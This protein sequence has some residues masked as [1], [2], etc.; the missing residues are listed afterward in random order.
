VTTFFQL[1]LD[2][3]INREALRS[4]I[5]SGAAGTDVPSLH[6]FLE[7]LSGNDLKYNSDDIDYDFPP[8]VSYHID[9]EIQPEGVPGLTPSD[10]S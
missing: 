7:V 1:E 5:L 3:L 6:T 9:S 2:H 10:Q 8:H 4:I